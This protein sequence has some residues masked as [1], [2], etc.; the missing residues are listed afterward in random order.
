MN[1]NKYINNI[2][3]VIFSHIILISTSI[4][5]QI[6]MDHVKGTPIRMIVLFSFMF[7]W[8][9]IYSILCVGRRMSYLYILTK[10]NLKI[11]L[12]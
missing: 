9:R 11:N 12:K 5:A 10:R 8:L 3:I 6:I 7:F 4:I 2:C 1:M